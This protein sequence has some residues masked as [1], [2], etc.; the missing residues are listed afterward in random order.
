MLSRAILHRVTH[1]T[2]VTIWSNPTIFIPFLYNILVSQT[3]LIDSFG[4]NKLFDWVWEGWSSFYRNG[5]WLSLQKSHRNLAKPFNIIIIMRWIIII[6]TNYIIPDNW[7]KQ[8]LYLEKSWFTAS[9]NPTKSIALVSSA[10]ISF[11]LL[12]LDRLG[13]L[14][15]YLE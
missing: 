1:H 3:A 13:P 2:K 7:R 10:I 5:L 14:V 11:N 9:R 15:R 4:R 12:E 8:I 6:K